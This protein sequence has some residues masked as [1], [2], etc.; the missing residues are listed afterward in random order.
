MNLINLR[1]HHLITAKLVHKTTKEV[2]LMGLKKLGY[3]KNK[4]KNGDFADFIYE[5]L[6]NIFANPNQQIKINNGGLDII[7]NQCP[8]LQEKNCNPLNP[9]N[10]NTFLRP[11]EDKTRDIEIIQQY[12]LDISRI[13][14][15]RE[16]RKIIKF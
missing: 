13:Y 14:S 6:R 16:L 10:Q 12:N 1:A 4:E 7:C 2:L 15:I 11:Y 8:K 5:G 9:Q 3:T